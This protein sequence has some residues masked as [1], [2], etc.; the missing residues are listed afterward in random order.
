M[1]T[2]TCIHYGKHEMIRFC[3]NIT[4]LRC[5][6]SFCYRGS[7]EDVFKVTLTIEK[8]RGALCQTNIQVPRL[9]RI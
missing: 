3:D 7:V 2:A 1:L 8:Q 4:E 5:L 9:K 6:T